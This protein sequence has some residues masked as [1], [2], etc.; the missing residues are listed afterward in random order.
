M[1]A[2][3]RMI[4]FMACLAAMMLLLAACATGPR[5]STDFDPQA[6]FAQYRTWAFYTPLA[7][8]QS[9][10][11]SYLSDSIKAG[12]RRE[13]TARGY[14]FDRENPDLL[15]NFQGMIE[16]RTNVYSV[17]RHDV[18]Y[19]YNYRAKAYFAVPVWYDETRVNE[20]TEGT[21]SVD[22]V[23]ADQNRLVWTGAAIGRVV[24]R[25]PQERAAEANEAITAIFMRFPY[26]AGS[27]ELAPMR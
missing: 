12:I 14:V 9:G 22:L 6:D 4:R 23:D 13:M 3:N 21:L 11:S 19:Y 16:E 5:V 25:T 15:V 1:Q 17:P 24:Q 27:A 20:Y 2:R 8:E 26:S 18:R 10:Y 7:M